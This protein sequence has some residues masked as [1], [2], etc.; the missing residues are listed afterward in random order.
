MHCRGSGD[1]GRR[2]TQTSDTL[3]FHEELS[4]SDHRKR[5]DNQLQTTSSCRP[6][7]LSGQRGQHASIQITYQSSFLSPFSGVNTKNQLN[8]KNNWIVNSVLLGFRM[9]F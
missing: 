3:S 5:S 1:L 9:K 8:L 4:C 7:S 6:H 2:V